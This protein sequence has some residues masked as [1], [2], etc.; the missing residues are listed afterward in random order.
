MRIMRK[1]KECRWLTNNELEKKVLSGGFLW[2][3]FSI[4]GFYAIVG[5]YLSVSPVSIIVK[6]L[7]FYICG[8]IFLLAGTATYSLE[9]KGTESVKWWFLSAIFLSISWCALGATSYY[10]WGG[11]DGA[12]KIWIIGFMV[13]MIGWYSNNAI[14]V[15]SLPLM[16]ISYLVLALATKD[17]SDIG[18]IAIFLSVAKFF[19]LAGVFQS[20]IG[21]LYRFARCQ[22][23]ER[24]NEINKL[25]SALNR[26][27]L[28]GVLN[29]KGFNS[30]IAAA[31]RFTEI[32][33][34]TMSLL[35]I[36]IDY[37]K[38]FNDSLGHP[39]GDACLT[40]LAKTI[41]RECSRETDMVARVG[42]EEFAV[43][44]TGCNE[45]QAKIVA[46][47]IQSAIECNA[48]PHPGSFISDFVTVSIGIAE[49]KG[50]G[51]DSLYKNADRALYKAK[52]LGKNRSC[53]QSEIV[54]IAE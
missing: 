2:N 30:G 33:K 42:G 31:I 3:M 4:L 13:M 25:E 19:L 17:E 51:P 54:C 23:E 45:E 28:T 14:L 36:D 24:S 8:I 52:Y 10:A 35:M 40:K 29:R 11:I 41:L 38:Q 44:L 6:G 5:F 43:I 20:S 22:Y 49:Y 18:T 1:V 32:K 47:R 37:F 15:G 7:N 12:E 46:D 50:T 26:D 34:A 21:K 39:A 9:R 53:T 27:E 16:I 48:T